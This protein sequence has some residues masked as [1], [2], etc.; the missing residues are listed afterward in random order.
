MLR[1]ISDPV[2]LHRRIMA[3]FAHV[4][5]SAAR[6]SLGVLWRSEINSAGQA[7]LTVQSNDDGD[8]SVLAEM[9]AT[10]EC[11][12][13]D[14]VLAALQLGQTLRFLLRANASRK[15]QTASTAAGARRNGTRVPLRSPEQALAWLVRHGESAGFEIFGG[16]GAPAV[17]IRSEPPVR[18]RRAGNVVTVEATRFEGLLT[19]KDPQALAQAVRAGIGPGKAYGCGLLSLAPPRGT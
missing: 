15:I 8:W 17:D 4:D 10:V 13:I 18:G 2:E 12:R 14:Q 5:D 9:T 7:A 11:K 19:V 1:A 3:G 6:A 16:P